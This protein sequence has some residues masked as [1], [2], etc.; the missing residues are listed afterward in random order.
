MGSGTQRRGE[1]DAPGG[2]VGGRRRVAAGEVAAIVLAI[3]R[4]VFEEERVDADS[5]AETVER[6]DSLG[7]MKLIA[8]LEEHFGIELDIMEMAD[9]DSVRA[10]VE[11]VDRELAR[12]VARG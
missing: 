7:H 10:L 6:W 1:G 8:V 4:E 5:T 2:A 9:V 12:P 3:C 11:A